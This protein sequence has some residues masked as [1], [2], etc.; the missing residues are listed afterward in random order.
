MSSKILVCTQCGYVG[1]A[2]GAIKGSILVEIFLWCLLIIPGLIYSAWR[3]SS[4]HT[5]C[6]KCKNPNLI[7]ADSPRAQ[8][9]MGETMSK[10]EVEEA[11]LKSKK[12][13]EKSD[14][15]K[16]KIYIAI[17]ISIGFFILINIIASLG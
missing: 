6:P 5:V 2:E 14:N 8:K 15:R 3:S 17:A 7:P 9:I 12:E 1:K 13:E 10:E 11:V 16:K 4:R